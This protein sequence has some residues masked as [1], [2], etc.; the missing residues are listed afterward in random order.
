[1]P[2]VTLTEDIQRTIFELLL[3][4]NIHFPLKNKPFKTYLNLSVDLLHK[5]IIYLFLNHQKIGSWLLKLIL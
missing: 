4:L 3:L 2:F 1:M 5:M